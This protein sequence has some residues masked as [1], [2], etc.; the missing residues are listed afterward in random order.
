MMLSGQASK[1]SV[2]GDRSGGRGRLRPGAI[3][4]GPKHAQGRS[5]DQVS[6][7]VEVVVYGGVCRAKPLR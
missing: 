6:L 3:G 5:A 2:G 7:N 1:A 4:L